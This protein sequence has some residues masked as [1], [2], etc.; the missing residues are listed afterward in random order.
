MSQDESS[1]IKNRIDKFNA[2]VKSFFS[3]RPNAFIIDTADELNESFSTGLL[4]GSYLLKRNWG[5]GGSFSLDGVHPGHTVHTHI[6]NIILQGINSILGLNAPLWDLA[7]VVSSDPYVDFDGD[8]WVAGPDLT[9]S[10][11]T[12][13]LYLFKDYQEGDPGPAVI[14]RMEPADVWALISSALLEEIIGIPL[15]R[16]EAE[17]IGAIQLKK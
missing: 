9:A 12:N 4:A 1:I 8:G 13:I 2:A 10:G 6:A 15:I 17:R 7:S 14:D 11:W 5:R 3:G 16:A